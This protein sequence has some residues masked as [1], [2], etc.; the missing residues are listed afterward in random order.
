MVKLPSPISLPYEIWRSDAGVMLSFNQIDPGGIA[1]PPA[2]S[3]WRLQGGSVFF[4][5]G[6]ALYQLAD[7]PAD[8]LALL[9]SQGILA[10]E[11][12]D[13]GPLREHWAHIEAPS[14]GL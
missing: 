12:G 8:A 14:K 2:L 9:S 11:F 3:G 6:T 10:V 1:S 13:L 7:M 5:R 4:E